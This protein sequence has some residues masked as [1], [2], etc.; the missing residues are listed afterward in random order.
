[1]ATIPSA[2]RII[3]SV[4]DAGNELPPSSSTGMFTIMV[5]GLLVLIASYRGMS[6]SVADAGFH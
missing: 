6:E 1:M 3:E 4:Y 5:P 2:S